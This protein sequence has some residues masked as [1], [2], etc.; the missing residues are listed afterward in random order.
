MD[1]GPTDGDF[2]DFV[3]R[4]PP[5]HAQSS[6][7]ELFKRAVDRQ[8]VN[9]RCCVNGLAEKRAPIPAQSPSLQPKVKDEPDLLNS[10]GSVDH[11]I[12]LDAGSS[13]SNTLLI[14]AI[15]LPKKLA[16]VAAFSTHP[17]AKRTGILGLN[18]PANLCEQR[19]YLGHAKQ[20]S[21]NKNNHGHDWHVF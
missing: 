7:H 1:N 16:S 2:N 11:L 20:L 3:K 19:M 5:L 14:I 18:W 15:L 21:K 17:A 12:E 8:D 10:T 13:I 9:C 4:A 6:G